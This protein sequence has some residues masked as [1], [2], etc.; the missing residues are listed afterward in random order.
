MFN[1]NHEN[2]ASEIKKCD[3]VAVLADETTD[4]TNQQ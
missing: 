2:V 1:A 4:M 3:D